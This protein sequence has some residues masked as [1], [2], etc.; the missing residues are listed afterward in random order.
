MT[1]E[2]FA[3]I[4]EIAENTRRINAAIDHALAGPPGDKGP[5]KG[6][7]REVIAELQRLNHP[8]LVFPGEKI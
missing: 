2:Q 3:L 5:R 6:W 8:M 4:R 7:A 1:D